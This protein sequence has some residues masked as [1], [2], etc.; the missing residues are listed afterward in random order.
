MLSTC[1]KVSNVKKHF[2]R[3]KKETTNR[4]AESSDKQATRAIQKIFPATDSAAH[5][6]LID[7]FVTKRVS[8]FKL[9]RHRNQTSYLAE[10]AES[11]KPMKT[12]VVSAVRSPLL[13]GTIDNGLCHI[14]V[15]VV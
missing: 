13:M 6:L 5:K 9:D 3:L 12:T 10:K 7:W 1:P 11:G 14:W 2:F 15:M 4:T 8:E